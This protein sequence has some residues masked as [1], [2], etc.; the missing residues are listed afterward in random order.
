MTT[1]DFGF[2]YAHYETLGEL[3]GDEKRVVE[4]ARE[5]CR[6]MAHAPYS[7]FRVGAAA[8]LESG[9]IIAA[10]NQESEV[11][12]A[13]ICAERNLLLSHVSAEPEER[14]VMMAIASAPDECECYPCGICRQTL[15]DVQKRQGQAIKVIMTSGSSATI[16]DDAS[17]LMPF[18]FGL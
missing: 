17:Y 16:V 11:F 18:A 9:K 3:A 14:I 7:N 4:A 12:P 2:K 10:G 5:A 8:I 1:K 6:T 13:G 15:S